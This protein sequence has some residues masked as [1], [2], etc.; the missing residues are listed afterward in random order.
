[1]SD[2]DRIKFLEAENE[3]LRAGINRAVD[4]IWSW[5][6]SSETGQISGIYDDLKGLVNT[7]DTNGN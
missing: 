5:M 1:M 3:R 2:Q 6:Y 7:G 4:A